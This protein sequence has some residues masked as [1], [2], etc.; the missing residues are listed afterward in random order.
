MNDHISSN[1]TQETAENGKKNN[2]KKY[3]IL[4]LA[5][6]LLI[7]TIGGVAVY[8]HRPADTGRVAEIQEK[9]ML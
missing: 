5:L 8:S 4:L 9:L 1:V 3:L 7:S 6:L 2:K